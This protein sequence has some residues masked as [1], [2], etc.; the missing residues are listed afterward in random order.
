MSELSGRRPQRI[1]V[2]PHVSLTACSRYPNFIPS[3]FKLEA[4]GKVIYID[5]YHIDDTAPADYI[6][7]THPHPDHLSPPDITQ[8]V[9]KETLIVCPRL[10]VGQ[11]SRTYSCHS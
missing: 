8:I 6:F 11:L 3:S 4:A 7:I 2:S 1:Q 10:F 5:P 9:K